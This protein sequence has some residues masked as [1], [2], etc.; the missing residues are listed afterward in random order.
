VEYPASWTAAF[1][2]I[3]IEQAIIGAAILPLIIPAYQEPGLIT[4]KIFLAH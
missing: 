3:F 4:N 1:F 2:T